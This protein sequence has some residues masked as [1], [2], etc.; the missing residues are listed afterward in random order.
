M[1][2]HSADQVVERSD[3]IEKTCF[4]I[5]PFGQ[6]RDILSDGQTQDIDFDQISADHQANRTAIE[7]PMHSIR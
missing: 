1:A 5:M 6:K 4:V 7:A 2:D 3:L